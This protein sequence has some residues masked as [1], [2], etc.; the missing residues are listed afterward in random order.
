VTRISVSP[1]IWKIKVRR[2]IKWAQ[3]NII[4]PILLN[5]HRMTQIAI[6]HRRERYWVVIILNGS[7]QGSDF[8]DPIPI[9]VIQ[10]KTP[11]M[12]C[13][14]LLKNSDLTLSKRRDTATTSSSSQIHSE[15]SYC[16]SI[17]VP[18]VGVPVEP[19]SRSSAK[20]DSIIGLDS[21]LFRTGQPWF[22]ISS[23]DFPITV[24]P[25]GNPWRSMALGK[26]MD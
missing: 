4:W 10:T 13:Y 18:P 12:W 25:S 5:L 20:T 19:S 21:S 23:A 1:V 8:L 26:G 11:S 22:G 3:T 14:Y 15:S 7:G 6:G 16:P 2:D 9:K 24:M 17:H